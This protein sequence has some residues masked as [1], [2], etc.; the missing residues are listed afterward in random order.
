MTLT[1]GVEGLYF[2]SRAQV[3]C[4]VALYVYAYVYIEEDELQNASGSDC[5]RVMSQ[6]AAI[7][8][9]EGLSAPSPECALD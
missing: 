3:G 1:F 7:R 8:Y 9:L 4:A 2:R 6:S 5:V